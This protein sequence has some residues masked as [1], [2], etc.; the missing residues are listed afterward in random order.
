MSLHI[1][2][3][4]TL[5]RAVSEDYTPSLKTLPRATVPMSEPQR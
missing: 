2:T 3:T 5:P 1:A 4:D